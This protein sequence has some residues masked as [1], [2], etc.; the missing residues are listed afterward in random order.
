MLAAVVFTTAVMAQ[1]ATTEEEMMLQWRQMKHKRDISQQAKLSSIP[2]GK[3]LPESKSTKALPED[4]VWFP[5]EWEEV[6]AV[7]VTPSYTY[8]PDSNLGSGYFSAEPMVT[9]VAEY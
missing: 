3:A 9:G 6:K 8:Q 5:G 7:I 1:N 4:R 2:L